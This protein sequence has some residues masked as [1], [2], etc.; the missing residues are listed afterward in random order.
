MAV[1]DLIG[2]SDLKSHPL[3]D[4]TESLEDAMGVSDDSANEHHEPLSISIRAILLA[5]TEIISPLTM[6]R[7]AAMLESGPSARLIDLSLQSLHASG[8]TKIYV[9]TQYISHSLHAHIQRTYPSFGF[10]DQ[11][12]F[13]EPWAAH[14]TKNCKEWFKSDF[15]VIVKLLDQIPEHEASRGL[16]EPSD[17]LILPGN[18]VH[19]VNLRDLIS[20]H[21]KKGA[22]VT[23]C[24]AR[25]ASV[26][27]SKTAEAFTVNKNHEVLPT[28]QNM[29]PYN[30][31]EFMKNMNIYVAK[32]DSLFRIVSE[33]VDYHSSLL[34]ASLEKGMNVSAYEYSGSSWHCI[35]SV[36][37]YF[38]FSMAMIDGKIN[39]SKGFAA[40]LKKPARFHGRNV[41]EKSNVGNGACI[42][43]SHI[44]ESSISENVQIY[45]NCTIYNSILLSSS[46]VLENAVLERCI[47]Q[48]NAVIGKGCIIRNTMGVLDADFTEKGYVIQNG[49]VIILKN[50]V[51]GEKTVI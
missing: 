44:Q 22:E 46:Q 9:P 11:E 6:D 36:E 42:A 16:G 27:S 17:Y 1:N 18:V 10:G 51:I 19:D 39:L 32:R 38:N 33:T 28:V 4:L 12:S 21:R 7:N 3:E 50:A 43:N 20:Y 45:N 47:V 15:N 48:E 24:A 8:I 26:I 37:N 25:Q 41:I 31:Q 40:M 34:S 49:Y 14:Q 5:H 13:V 23:V 35:D 30:D 29:H 2:E